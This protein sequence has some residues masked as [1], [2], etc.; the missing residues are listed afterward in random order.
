MKIKD[1]LTEQS[2]IKGEFARNSAHEI[3]RH[4]D[5]T[6]TS[7]CLLGLMWHCY[8]RKKHKRIALKIITYLADHNENKDIQSWNDEEHRTVADVKKL[9]EALDI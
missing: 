8:Q 9:V 6:A 3:V 5:P 7:W 4:D 2:W 1:I